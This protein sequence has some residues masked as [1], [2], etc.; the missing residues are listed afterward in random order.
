M[1]RASSLV[2]ILFRAL[3]GNAVNNVLVSTLLSQYP[4]KADANPNILQ[5]NWATRIHGS[6]ARSRDLP[7]VAC[8]IAKLL[9]DMSIHSNLLLVFLYKFHSCINVSSS[10]IISLPS[11][12]SSSSILA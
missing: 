7:Q 5:I 9:F 4:S 2:P 10:E 8:P 12:R 3:V 1:S 6:L 11:I